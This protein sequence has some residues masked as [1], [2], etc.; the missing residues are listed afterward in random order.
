[1]LFEWDEE[2]RR[3]VLAERGIDLLEAV[4]VFEGPVLTKVDSRVDY[5]EM[6]HISLGL[7][8][9]EPF[10]VV[11]TERHGVTRLITAWKGGERERR[12]YQAGIAER[13]PEDEG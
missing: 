9:G 13:H 8:D 12:D 3:K 1:M 5:G 11:H 2:K 10:V 7:V 6:R 4:L